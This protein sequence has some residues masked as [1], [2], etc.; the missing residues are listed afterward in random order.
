MLITSIQLQT[1][2]FLSSSCELFRCQNIFSTH[3]VGCK[4]DID[5]NL[6]VIENDNSGTNRR[7][8]VSRHVK[9]HIVGFWRLIMLKKNTIGHGTRRFITCKNK[10]EYIHLTIQF[11][12][13][14]Q[15]LVSDLAVKP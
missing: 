15:A 14:L 7:F 13:P 1:A 6:S 12:F 8:L 3:W 9:T 4:K 5:V 10:S 11:G 2:T